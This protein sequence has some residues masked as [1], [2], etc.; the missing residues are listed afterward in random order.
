MK[1]KRPW[2]WLI[3]F[4]IHLGMFC[5]FW[6]VAD[7]ILTAALVIILLSG[8]FHLGW[9]IKSR[10][11]FRNQEPNAWAVID[12]ETKKINEIFKTREAAE[13]FTGFKGK[14]F[15]VVPVHVLFLRGKK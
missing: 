2:E 7:R 10:V 6:A 14:L 9:Y 4:A 1:L 13:R 8:S 3:W 15:K 5:F 11:I 12:T